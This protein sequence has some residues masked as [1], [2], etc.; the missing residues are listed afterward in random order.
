MTSDD[1]KKAKRRQQTLIAVMLTGE[2]AMLRPHQ[3]KA[4]QPPTGDHRLAP[5]LDDFS[6]E[7]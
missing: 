6:F 4:Q 5:F 7:M 3:Q 1:E 2:K